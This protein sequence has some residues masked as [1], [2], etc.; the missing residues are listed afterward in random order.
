MRRTSDV[1]MLLIACV[2]G[3]A[4]GRSSASGEFEWVPASDSVDTSEWVSL[5]A[6]SPPTG[7]AD[8]LA[9]ATED[10]AWATDE[11][12]EAS[13]AP[14]PLIEE[15]PA[16]GEPLWT[17]DCEA[18]CP[19]PRH[20]DCCGRRPVCNRVYVI[21][22]AVGWWPAIHTFL[23]RLRR[24]GYEPDVYMFGGVNCA[25]DNL[26]E[27]RRC[28]EEAGPVRIIGYSLGGHGAFNMARQLKE[29]GVIVDRLLLVECFSNPTITSNVRYCFNIYETRK[30]DSWLI[31]RGTPVNRES[32]DTQLVNIDVAVEPA[33]RE[34]KSRNH[35]TMADDTRVQQTLIHLLSCN[36]IWSN[37]PGRA[38]YSYEGP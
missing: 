25:V 8:D 12:E 35:F 29:R 21:R 7:P 16:A 18:Q 4:V 30:S 3:M 20:D 38:V 24:H 1:W 37:V 34:Q 19:A 33:W 27:R 13:T 15:L 36:C 2:I 23:A 6:P 32:W 31:F 14:I 26:I 22:G 9:W 28:G 5:P 17:C 10:L 11:S